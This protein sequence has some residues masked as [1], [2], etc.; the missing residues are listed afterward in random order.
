[1]FLQYELHSIRRLHEESEV[2]N[3][4][5]ISLHYPS[6]ALDPAGVVCSLTATV[7]MHQ[8]WNQHK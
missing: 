2:S 3:I 8:Y 5:P 7:V 4:G 6:E 1:M